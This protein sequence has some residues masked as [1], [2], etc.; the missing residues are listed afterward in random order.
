MQEELI[1]KSHTDSHSKKLKDFLKKKLEINT[2]TNIFKYN[3]FNMIH[4]NEYIN[5]NTI[6][7]NMIQ[8]YFF[9]TKKIS[10]LLTEKLSHQIQSYFDNDYMLF[11]KSTCFD[12]LW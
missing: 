9:W 4:S 12:P 2:N 1:L 11:K 7:G 6:P 5:D 8:K 3:G 10:Q